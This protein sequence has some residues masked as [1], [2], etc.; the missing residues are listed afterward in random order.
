MC[1]AVCEMVVSLNLP[2]SPVCI[3]QDCVRILHQRSD[4]SFISQAGDV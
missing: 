2:N 4:L 3:P 1:V